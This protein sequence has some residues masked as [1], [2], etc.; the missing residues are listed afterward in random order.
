MN[1]VRQLETQVQELA[2]VIAF[3]FP[4]R[5]L[6]IYGYSPE[7]IMILEVLEI[8]KYKLYTNR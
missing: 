3:P 4:Q 5:F 8:N 6:E 2:V 7:Y 1:L